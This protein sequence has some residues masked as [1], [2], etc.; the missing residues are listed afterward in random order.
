MLIYRANIAIDEQCV[1]PVE[2]RVLT[3]FYRRWSTYY[4]GMQ[5][6]RVFTGFDLHRDCSFDNFCNNIDL[7][8]IKLQNFRLVLIESIFKLKYVLGKVENIVGKGENAGYQHFLLFPRYFQ[9]AF[10]PNI[11][12]FIYLFSLNYR[13]VYLRI[14]LLNN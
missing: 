11:D 13:I 12:S 1:I 8:I 10:F 5:I 7:P 14:N 2:R 3:C 6:K 4:T 9:N